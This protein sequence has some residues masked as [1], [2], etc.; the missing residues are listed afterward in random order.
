LMTWAPGKDRENVMNVTHGEGVYLFDDK[1]NR[2]L[3]WTSQAVCSNLG[4]SIPKEIIDA[5]AY[6]MS[7]VP[8]LYGGMG[9]PEVRVRLNQLLNELL[10]GDLGV[11]VYP[12]SGAEANEAGMMMARRVTG[13]PK[14]LS[15]FRS[16]HGAT[17]GAGAATGDSRRW[18]GSDVVPGHIKA[19]N[20][21]PL[22]F[23]HGAGVFDDDYDDHDTAAQVES[24][25]LMLEEQIL[26]EGPEEIASFIVE[27]I[28]G[29]GGCLVMPVGYMQGVRAICD[30]YGILLHFDEVM[31]GFG[32]TGKMF[33]FQHYDGV[34]P[35]IVTC[36]KGISSSS[37][38][39]SMTACRPHI[40]E[41]FDNKPL[42][43]GSTYQAHAVA[44]AAAYESIK[45]LVKNDVINYVGNEIGP[46]FEERMHDIAND[47]PCIK[48]YRAVGLFGCLDVHNPDGTIPR[49]QHEKA[50]EAFVKYKKAYKEN[51]L[52]GLH[53]YPHIHCAPPLVINK[54]ELL[55]GFDRLDQT[56]NVLDEELGF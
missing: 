1:G 46:I 11:A 22:F 33:G 35:D 17:A 3:D 49:L 47:H 12:S 23:S 19:F 24:A 48:Q 38:P 43:W 56:L 14:I 21:F 53:R 10:P 2:Y 55:D 5:A 31:V 30:K 7:V 28:V 45:Y 50:N 32:R 6:Q 34:L 20:P 16:Y 44:M 9:I 25:L 18:Y 52:N 39:L 51:G 40:M 54:D 29:A 15:W 37:V 8:F 36:A 41:A 42:G 26:N 13:R 4:H 27:P